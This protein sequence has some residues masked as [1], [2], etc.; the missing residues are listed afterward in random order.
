METG[1]VF[2][3]LLGSGRSADVYAIDGQWVLRRYRDGGDA[4]AEAVVMAYLGDN[5]YPVP[6]VR[7]AAS[8]TDLVLQ[9]LSG[10]TML[11][12]L[13]RGETTPEGAGAMLAELLRRLHAIP[14]RVSTDPAARTLHLD[15]HPDNVM[16][17]PDGPMV[18]DW[19]NTAEGPAGLD[20]GMS[21]VIL[22]QAA[23]DP[24]IEA[25]EGAR[26]VLAALLAHADGTL[27]L[28]DAR[29]R[30]AA[31]PNLSRRE[32]ELL[33]GAEALVRQLLLQPDLARNPGRS[34]P[35]GNAS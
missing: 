15:L 12:S 30:R 4:T 21:A 9:R 24:T 17:T 31:D 25:A 33:D 19:S 6:R 1:E 16:L 7:P 29:A 32:V 10:P 20:W 26:A 18:I 27:A 5:G 35:G 23:V 8:H 2:G 14:A 28:V 13:M 22:A 3:E 11:Q 34:R